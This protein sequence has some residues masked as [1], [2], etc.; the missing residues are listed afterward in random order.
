MLVPLMGWLA[1]VVFVYAVLFFIGKLIFMEWIIAGA[2]L[3]VALAAF[4]VVRYSL[5]KIDF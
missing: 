4:F 5:K 2:L 3:A 1:A